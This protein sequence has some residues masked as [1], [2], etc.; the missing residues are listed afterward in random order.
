ME[1]N[2]FSKAFVKEHRERNF[3]FDTEVDL[4]SEIVKFGISQHDRILHIGCCDVGTD[5]IAKLEKLKIDSFYLGVDVKEEINNLKLKYKDI[6]NYTFVQQPIQDFIEE[7]LSEYTNGDIF[8]CTVL[9]GL[10]DKPTY[11]ERHY[12]FIST[13]I[14]RCMLFS[15]KVIFSINTDSYSKHSYSI[16]YVMN[17]LM[18]THNHVTIKKIKKNNYIFCITH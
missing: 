13:L 6:P 8:E 10:F 17:I 11:E 14:E 18:N 4:P 7:Q 5:L 15:D 12:Q 3:T 2:F 16:I 1:H 9:T